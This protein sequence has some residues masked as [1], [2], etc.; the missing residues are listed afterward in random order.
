MMKK[1]LG[2]LSMMGFAR[3]EKRDGVETEELIDVCLNWRREFL[4]KQAGIAMH[5]FLG[6]TGGQFADAIMAVDQAAFEEMSKRHSEAETSEAFMSLLK[7]DSIRLTPNVILKSGV[8][9]PSDFSCIEF[10]TFQSKPEP[11][12]SESA[13]L[14]VSRSIEAEYLSNHSETRE[15]FMGK[16][17]AGVY[18]E[19]AF[20]QTLGAAREICS[21][22]PGNDVCGE[23]LA[24]FDPESVDLDFWYV[25]A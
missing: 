8:E 7:P 4:N 22:Y 5:C 17:S 1:D 25:L 10:G 3:Y 19:V 12:F 11:G 23:L 2:P 15:H 16:V 14:A 9:V 20:V 24:M 18:S 21:G 6:N 13:M